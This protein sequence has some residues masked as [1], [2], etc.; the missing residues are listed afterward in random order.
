MGEP[1]AVGIDVGGTKLVAAALDSRGQVVQRLRRATPAGDAA[2]LAASLRE[3]VVE[4]GA[5]LPVGV[6]AAGLVAPDGIVRYGPNLRV[7][8]LDVAGALREVT[9]APVVVVNDASAAAFGEQQIG[10]ARG[11]RDVVMLTIGTGIGGGLVVGGELVVGAR[12]FGGELGHVIVEEG[13]RRC[14]C[15]TRGCVEAYASGT[16]IA[17]IAEDRLA[18]R[19]GDSPLAAIGPLSG[20]DVTFAARDGDELA[21]SVLEDAG[22]WLGVALATL[23]NALDPEIVLLGGGAAAETSRWIVPAAATSMAERII[24]S[25]WRDPP[26]IELAALGDDAGIVGAGLLAASRAGLD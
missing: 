19:G 14:P 7:R 12:G 16:S 23:V 5:G 10:A 3:L 21:R 26:A 8:D 4:L 15:G 18:E 2:G 17:R 11:H 6:G 24:G 22:R 9:S 1:V 25:D 20:K 13:G